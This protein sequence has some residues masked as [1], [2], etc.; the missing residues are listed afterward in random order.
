MSRD[1]HVLLC[2]NVIAPEGMRLLEPVARLSQVGDYC[3]EEERIEAARTADAML[4]RTGAVTHALVDQAPQL[5]IVARHGVGYDAVDVQACT[6]HGVLVT[7]TPNANATAVSEHALA[8]M[9]AAARKVPQADAALKA[10]NWQREPYLGLEL[11]GKTLGLVGLGRV[12]SKVARLANAFGMTVLGADPYANAERAA[13]LG[14][15]LLPL[16]EMLPQCDFVS[17]HAPLTPETH[18]II[19]ERTLPLLKETAILVNTARGGL[20]DPVALHKALL[21]GRPAAA[22]LD[23]FEQEPFDPND[24]LPK[25]PNV[26][27][28]P[29]LGGQ[30]AEALVNM[31]TAAAEAILDV[32]AGRRP[33]GL[34][35]PE[36]LSHTTRV[37]IA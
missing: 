2:G 17:V 9:L 31:A 20:V 30:T 15:T 19:G 13:E 35:N 11:A 23:V 4:V 16:E 21:A 1:Y 32:F 7:I 36:V 12:G 29:H 28:T 10:G 33:D 34:I 27:V 5:K 8:L 6:E 18:H 14:V 26:I 22:A 37:Q 25:L 3:T 24:P